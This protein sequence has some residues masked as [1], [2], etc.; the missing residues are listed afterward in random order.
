MTGKHVLSIIAAA[1]GNEAG[2][3]QAAG[4]RLAACLGEA[5][6]SNWTVGVAFAPDRGSLEAS[7]SDAICVISLAALLDDL[8]TP[9]AAVEAGLRADLAALSA[10]DRRVVLLTV[11]RH[12]EPG[13]DPAED[14]RRL[15]RLRRLNLLAAN[16]SQTY[17]AFV[18]DVDRDLA[19][20]GARRLE[21]DYRLGGA[22][23]TDLASWTLAACILTNALDGL[24]SF[25]VQ[26]AAIAANLG[27]KPMTA[28][29][30]DVMATNLIRLGRGRR[31]QRVASVT[32]EIQTD[33]AQRL[34]TQVIRGQVA[35]PE[36]LSRISGA[37]RRRGALETVR[38]FLSAIRRPSRQ[39]AT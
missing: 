12:I 9:W 6:G 24:A 28:M 8:D 29:T 5:D 37:M 33:H 26:D 18:A 2:V 19:D 31:R 10:R 7:R 23:A 11:L 27:H 13:P 34:V 21:T 4:S 25:D 1:S 35:L 14:H 22:A 36:A 15:V 30:D 38:L 32:V 20:V 17:S 39:R 3:V 16:L